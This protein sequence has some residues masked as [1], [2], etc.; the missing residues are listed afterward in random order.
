MSLPTTHRRMTAAEYFT[1]PEGPPYFQVVN[2]E[3]FM[4]PSPLLLHQRVSMF[5]AGVLFDYLRKNPIGEVIPAPS[6]V[7]LGP[8]DVFQPDIYYVSRERAGILNEQGADG[9]PD[10]VIEILSPSTAR[11]DLE[12]KREVYLR[13]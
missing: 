8:E 3:L 5:L 7:Q 10:L 9:A 6:D 1:L 13:A 2:G 12:R 4:S 11:L